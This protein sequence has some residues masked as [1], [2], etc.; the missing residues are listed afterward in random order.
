MPKVGLIALSRRGRRTWLETVVTAETIGTV[1]FSV[2]LVAPGVLGAGMGR[3]EAVEAN[4]NPVSSDVAMIWPVGT[5]CIL[6]WR[7]VLGAV[8]HKRELGS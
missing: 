6:P 2:V 3:Q 1:A 8:V 7:T 4:E 5:R